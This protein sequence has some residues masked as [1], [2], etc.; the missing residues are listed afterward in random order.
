MGRSVGSRRVDDVD[1]SIA[2][3]TVTFALDGQR[4]EI[5][6]SDDNAA[7]L[8][9]VFAPYIAAGRRTRPCGRTTSIN[10]KKT[11]RVSTTSAGSAEEMPDRGFP[12]GTLTDCPDVQGGMPQQE[13]EAPAAAPLAAVVP[14]QSRMRG[15]LVKP[16]IAGQRSQLIAGAGELVRVAAV[17]M[18]AAAADRLVALIVKPV[19]SKA[20][21]GVAQTGGLDGIDGSSSP[22]GMP[23]TSMPQTSSAAP[24]G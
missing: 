8:R 4:F 12:A 3:Q 21:A 16:D 2:S 23:R 13:Q 20:S 17:A 19:A 5:D 1:G 24:A 14:L 7:A 11:V 10:S 6:L 18:L 15:K 22:S 9:D